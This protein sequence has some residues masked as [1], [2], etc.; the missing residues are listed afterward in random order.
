MRLIVRDEQ[1]AASKYVADYIINR[2]KTFEPTESRPFILGLPTGSSPTLIYKLLVER[3]RTGDISFKHV[4][5]FNM[6]SANT[7]L[8]QSAQTAN[9][10]LG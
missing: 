1:I 8:S 9:V 6:V 4:V 5:T 10:V 3:Y 7:V 2:I